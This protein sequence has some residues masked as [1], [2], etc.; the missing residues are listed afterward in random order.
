MKSVFASV[1][2]ALWVAGCATQSKQLAHEPGTA[3]CCVCKYNHDLACLKVKVD[4][5]TPTVESEG[6][7]LC[8]CSEDCRSAFLKN[9][10][11][12]KRFVQGK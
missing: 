11:K 5:S 1:L 10:A 3:E 7:K 12:Y 8:F 4:D 2:M 9:P 6:K